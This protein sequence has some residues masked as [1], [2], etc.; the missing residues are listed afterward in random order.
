MPKHRA[1]AAPPP[2]FLLFP[3]FDLFLP[4]R[5][6][7]GRKRRHVRKG[8]S[9]VAR[10]HHRVFIVWT[11]AARIRGNAADMASADVKQDTK[12]SSE[13]ISIKV[14]QVSAL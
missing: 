12:E 10:E 5:G 9:L 2:P 6:K 13:H 4:P 11:Q 14:K 8:I 3:L 1:H 7:Q